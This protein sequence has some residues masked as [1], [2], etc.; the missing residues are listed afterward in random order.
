MTEQPLISVI[1]PVYNCDRYLS[2]AIESVLAQSYRPLEIL[3]IDDGSIDN[4]AEIAKSFIPH[5]QYYYQPHNGPATAINYGINLSNGK[6]L[7]FLDSDDLW[8]DSNKLTKQMQVLQ[9]YPS[10]DLVFSYVQQFISPE[11]DEDYKRKIDILHEIMPAYVRGGLLLKRETLLQVGYFSSD[12]HT[13]DFV[14]WYIRAKE[15]G[16]KDLVIPEI[17]LKRRIHTTNISLEKSGYRN[18]YA[19]IIKKS[20]DRRRNKL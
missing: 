18:D 16:L 12:W 17:Y 14:D 1:I 5:I 19:R 4:S 13:V 15:L 20:L 10:V 9:K 6:F 7:A 8:S 3:I 2:E 11:L